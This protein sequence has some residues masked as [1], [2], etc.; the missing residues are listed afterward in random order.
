MNICIRADGGSYIGMGHVMR[1][2][3][4]AKELIKYHNV[5]Y[6][7]R[8][9]KPLSDKYKPGIDKIKSEG[10]KVIYIDENDIINGISKIEADCIIT[11]SYDVNEEYFNRVKKMF[12]ISGC[13]DDERTCSYFNVDFLIN[14][15]IYGNKLGYK[16][17]D[18]TELM[19]GC[20]YVILREEFRN[21]HEK[22]INR[23]IEKIMITVGGS[24]NDNLT[25]KILQNISKLNAK[26]YVVIGPGFTNINRLM[27]YKKY[28]VKVC[29][30]PVMSELM[31]DCD[32]AIASCGTTLFEL[33]ACGT[34][35]IGIVAAENQK[36][37]AK[38]MDKE[39]VIKYSSI[40]NIFNTIKTL[41]YEKRYDMSIKGKKLVDGM[42]I[43]RIVDNIE[44]RL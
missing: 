10:F 15:N 11:D 2:L 13:L 33:A 28:N 39:G 41:D 27:K 5:F 3:A 23:N 30:N 43:K 9:D 17:N 35:T 22:I 37:A 26:V 18:D 29:V 19:L 32:A 4:V 16:V 31:M 12:K 40:E 14:Q 21:L 25:K 8:M 7:C 6:A 42:G 1:T 24:D 34:P 36:F 20:D 38:Y 44:R